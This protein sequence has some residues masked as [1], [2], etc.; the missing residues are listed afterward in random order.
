MKKIYS[1]LTLS[2]FGLFIGQFAYAIC[3]I[4]V[5]GIGAGLGLSRWLGVDDLISSIWIGGLLV[6]LAAWTIDWLNRKN[7]HFVLRDIIIWLAYYLLVLLPLYLYD[8]AGHPLNKFW[9]VDKILLGTI[10]GTVIAV[11]AI[12]LHFWLKKKNGDKVYFPYQKVAI[13]IASLIITSLIVYF[14]LK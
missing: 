9:G 2:G 14:L 11:L 1:V 10:I 4:C 8:I 12:V 7:I 3:P 13:P 6:A 5:V